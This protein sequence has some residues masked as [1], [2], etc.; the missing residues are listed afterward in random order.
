M[1]GIALWRPTLSL[2]RNTLYGKM[3]QKSKWKMSKMDL[4][5]L[6]WSNSTIGN[7]HWSAFICPKSSVDTV[8]CSYHIIIT[9]APVC[10]IQPMKLANEIQNLR[11]ESRRCRSW[12]QHTLTFQK[13]LQ[14][15]LPLISQREVNWGSRH[16]LKLPYPFMCL[17]S[18]RDHSR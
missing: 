5:S 4:K 9:A 16:W 18:C 1:R 13:P 7:N 3:P 15:T 2:F 8:M 12:P 10:L 6:L 11:K 17:W 14:S